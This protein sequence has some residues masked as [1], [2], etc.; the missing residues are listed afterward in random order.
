MQILAAPFLSAVAGDYESIATT[1]VGS[2]GQTPITFSAIPG[3]YKHLQLRIMGRDARGVTLNNVYARFNGDTA[4]NY[5]IHNLIGNGSSA[6]SENFLSETGMIVALN[7]G[8]SATANIFGVSIVDILDYAVT[9]K[10]KT[11]RSLTGCDQNGSGSV[12][13]WSGNWRS[14]SAITS[15]TLYS[16]AT[17]NQ[18]Q[19]SSF[20]LYGIKG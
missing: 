10:Y 2:G 1:T 17:P 9:D 19:H 15:I 3:T 12:R 20:A 11:V 18:S 4:A 6:V 13:L 7:A 8:N 5:S 14:L 16:D